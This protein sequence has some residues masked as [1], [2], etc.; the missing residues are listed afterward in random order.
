[1]S[2]DIFYLIATQM[3]NNSS[4]DTVK[5]KIIKKLFDL[6]MNSDLIEESKYYFLNISCHMKDK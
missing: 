1:M 4:Y 6:A 3:V 5:F 2:M